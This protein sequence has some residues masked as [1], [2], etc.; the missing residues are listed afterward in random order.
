MN[1]KNTNENDHKPFVATGLQEEERIMKERATPRERLLPPDALEAKIGE[2]VLREPATLPK[3][4]T[5]R[6]AVA[7]LQER[8]CSACLVVDAEGALVG[9]FTERDVVA[10]CATPGDSWDSTLLESVMTPSPE[11][12]D[13][14]AT[15]AHA[16]ETMIVGEYRHVPIL[17]G[18]RPVAALSMQDVMRHL[19]GFFPDRVKNLPPRDELLEPRKREGA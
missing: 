9:I 7:T 19:R 10:R 13:K 3:D 14:D 12:L 5:V 4:A 16:I 6:K 18:K 11:T 17:D 1:P 15:L 2:I 8:G